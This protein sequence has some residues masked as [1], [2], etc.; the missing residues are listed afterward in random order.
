M[1]AEDDGW[2][3]KGKKAVQKVAHRVIIGGHEGVGRINTVV[4][5]LVPLG[6]DTTR[7]GV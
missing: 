4:P 7:W 5:G 6:K 1:E 2:K 3:I